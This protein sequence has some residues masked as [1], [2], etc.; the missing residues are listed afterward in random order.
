M[1][2]KV[3]RLTKD[4]VIKIKKLVNKKVELKEIA[5]QFNV[6]AATISQIKLGVTWNWLLPELIDKKNPNVKLTEKQVRSIKKQL[7]RGVRLKELAQKYNV[8]H[9]TISKIK[10]GKS[11]KH[12]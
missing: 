10:T 1:R 6:C 12:V 11:W 3:T 7:R 2:I 4:D 9:R 8:N 5:L